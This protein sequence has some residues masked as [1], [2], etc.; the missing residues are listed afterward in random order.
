MNNKGSALVPAM[1][2]VVI[3]VLL[4]VV[5]ASYVSSMHTHVDNVL[6]EN[7]LDNSDMKKV[8]SFTQGTNKVLILFAILIV[9]ILVIVGIGGE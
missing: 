9:A 5:G 3:L 4:A 8:D 7:G 2:V 1:G 6:R